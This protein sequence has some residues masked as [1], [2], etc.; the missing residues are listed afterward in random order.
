MPEGKQ[1]YLIQAEFSS[2][3][4]VLFGVDIDA[5]SFESG[6]QRLADTMD[7]E[8]GRK[9]IQVRHLQMLVKLTYLQCPSCGNL[10]PAGDPEC[11][12]CHM[13]MKQPEVIAA[14]QQ[15][16]MRVIPKIKF[17]LKALTEGTQN[18]YRIRPEHLQLWDIVPPDSPIYAQWEEA[19][20]QATRQ[21][22][23][24]KSGLVIPDAIEGAMLGKQLKDGPK[25]VR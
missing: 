25:I 5:G 14:I 20:D 19:A 13:N 11:V 2:G 23:A 1:T 6:L 17:Q 4:P 22:A 3:M 12:S 18:T 10:T 7:K 21:I 16:K 24:L 15:G 9:F 8:G